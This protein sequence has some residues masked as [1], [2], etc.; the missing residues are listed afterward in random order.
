MTISRLKLKSCLFCGS[1]ARVYCPYEEGLCS[2]RCWGCGTDT[3]LCLTPDKAVKLWNT[4]V[5]NKG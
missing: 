5:E 2:V 3:T 4:R 1:K